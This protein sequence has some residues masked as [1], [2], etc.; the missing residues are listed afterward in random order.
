MWTAISVKGRNGAREATS[1]RSF[2]AVQLVPPC[3]FLSYP[4]HL[5]LTR[6]GVLSMLR[7][8][9]HA[10]DMA[11]H[12]KEYH[13]ALRSLQIFRALYTGIDAR[14]SRDLIVGLHECLKS[15]LPHKYDFSTQ[16]CRSSR[17]SKSL[18]SLRC[19]EEQF[20]S[21]R[22][23]VQIACVTADI[24]ESMTPGHLHLF[25]S[26]LWAN[27]ALLH[28]GNELLIRDASR[29]ITSFIMPAGAG[30]FLSKMSVLEVT[31]PA[32]WQPW[33]GLNPT[34]LSI[35]AIY[36]SVRLLLELKPAESVASCLTRRLNGDNGCRCCCPWF[37]G[38]RPCF[39][40]EL[41]QCN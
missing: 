11:M 4:C 5:F 35:G 19:S 22:L 14:S 18:L 21:Q 1:W 20:A 27:V 40:E 24:F 28:S 26:V 34:L 33:V 2:C 39:V 3:C 12:S 23:R 29:T 16:V 13:T 36:S 10:L 38:N 17:F 15:N 8:A 6:L 31:I 9:F 32:P 7:W 37:F 41:H 30:A 25:P